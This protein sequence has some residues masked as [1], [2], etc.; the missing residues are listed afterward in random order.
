MTALR[1]AVILWGLRPQAA[2]L[3]PATVGL[4]PRGSPLGKDFALPQ[5]PSP[6]THPT[7]VRCPLNRGRVRSRY[8]A[9]PGPT[10]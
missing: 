6:V 10:A 3:R 5:T 8:G 9:A 4:A 2:A 1:A 7:Q